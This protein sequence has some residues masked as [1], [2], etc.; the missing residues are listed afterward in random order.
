[1]NRL[2]NRHLGSL[3]SGDVSSEA[4]VSRV[5]IIAPN[6]RVD[7][8]LPGEAT[9]GELLPGIV[10][11]AGFEGATPTE[12]VH[13]WVLQRVGED[14][15]DPNQLVTGL[16]IRDGE[17]LH[18][19]HRENAMPDAAFDDVVD[20]VNTTVSKRPSWQPRHSQRFTI[21]L[22][23]VLVTLLPALLLIIGTRSV[24]PDERA[25]FAQL[26]AIGM[27]TA[28]V[29]CEVVAIVLSRAAGRYAVA[30]TFAWLAIALAGVGG[31]FI[32]GDADLAIRI[33]MVSALTLVMAATGA[34]A[35][36]VTV[37]GLFTVGL[38]A[39]L[40]LI[41]SSIA[42][43]LA[44][45]TSHAVLAIVMVLILSFTPSLPTLSY[46]VAQIALPVLPTNAEGI[47]ADQEPVQGDIVQRAI[48]ADKLLAAFLGASSAVMVMT[49]LPLL[50][51]PTWWRI[52]LL[53]AT[54]LALVLRA[55]SF[56]G[57]TQRLSLLLGGTILGL[58]TLAAMASKVGLG[59][60]QAAI[61][62][63]IMIVAIT[64]LAYYAS[65]SY[66]KVPSPVWGRWGD[67]IEWISVIAVLPLLLG[68]LDLYSRLNG[69]KP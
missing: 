24:Y 34:L 17:M 28:A 51:E 7:L 42:T 61:I 67:V 8:A 50:L 12:A 44:P 43:L 55:R 27:L 68:V 2:S 18:L 60:I 40:M 39:A 57:L 69:W 64:V 53:A 13:T 6:R 5:T 36:A 22:I 11:F 26:V 63:L 3:R 58:A 65:V 25:G 46:Q 47:L 48:Q 29:A 31:W 10:R 66:A 54:S 30:T 35:A 16:N 59:P 38:T 1:M 23:T 14:P 15:L 33:V 19:R 41:V 4:D 37:M 45:G 20:A 49:G 32:L 62:A 52:G 21:A 9:L 56:V